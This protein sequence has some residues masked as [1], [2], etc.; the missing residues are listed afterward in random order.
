[1]SKY[2]IPIMFICRRSDGA[3]MLSIDSYGK[4]FDFFFFIENHFHSHET[5][6]M[7]AK[8]IEIGSPFVA[9]KPK[10]ILLPSEIQKAQ[11]LLK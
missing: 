4:I 7:P 5:W 2:Q 1:M 6:Q 11:A 8:V 3:H 10:V 9:N